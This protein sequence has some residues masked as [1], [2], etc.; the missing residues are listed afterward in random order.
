MK[1]LD[2]GRPE[3]GAVIDLD[4]DPRER[5]LEQ[6]V[7][8]RAGLERL[9]AEVERAVAFGQALGAGTSAIEVPEELRQALDKL[10]Y[11]EGPGE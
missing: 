9:R 2:R 6:G 11:T 8:A 1:V 4:G 10:G 7:A 5:R 3:F